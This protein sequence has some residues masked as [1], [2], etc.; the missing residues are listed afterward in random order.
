MISPE[1]ERIMLFQKVTVDEGDKKG[2]VELW[3]SELEDMMFYTVKDFMYQ[4]F[5]VYN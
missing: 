4:A 1:D 2:N 5:L 3:M